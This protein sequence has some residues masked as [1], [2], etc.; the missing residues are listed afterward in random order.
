LPTTPGAIYNISFFLRTDGGTP[1]E[2]DVEFGGTT[3]SDVIN[4]AAHG[5][6]IE[7][8]SQIATSGSTALTFSFRDDPGFMS[9]DDVVVVRAVPEPTSLAL[10]FVSLLGFGVIR[11]RR[12]AV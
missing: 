11:R 5:Y 8:F 10:F 12:D 9:L 3:L 4:P 2:F 6:A 1:S 7:T